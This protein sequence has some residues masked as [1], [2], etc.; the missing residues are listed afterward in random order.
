VI[1]YDLNRNS[2]EPLA[3]QITKV[4]AHGITQGDWKVGDVLPSELWLAKQFGV[5]RDTVRQ[6][7]QKLEREGCLK[8]QRGRGTFIVRAPGNHDFDRRRPVSASAASR[9]ADVPADEAKA[10]S[11]ISATASP[12]L[13]GITQSLRSLLLDLSDETRRRDGLDVV[14]LRQLSR[15]ENRMRLLRVQL[16]VQLEQTQELLNELQAQLTRHKAL[17]QTLVRRAASGPQTRPDPAAV[18]LDID[19]L[20]WSLYHEVSQTVDATGFILAI[21]DESSQT[22]NVVK[23][24]EAGTELPTGSFPLGKGFTSEV[25]RTRQPRLIRRWSKEGPRVQIQYATRQPG[26]PESGITLPLLV[27]DRVLGVM[28]VQSYQPEAYSEDDLLKL[29]AIADRAAIELAELCRPGRSGGQLLRRVSEL[30]TVLANMTDGMLVVDAAGC[31][32]HLNRAAREL[33]CDADH[34]I[35]LGQPL[36]EERWGQRSLSPPSAA[37]A[38][39]SVIKALQQGE[40][41]CEVAVELPGEPHRVLNC[42]GTA[43]RDA[44]GM[45]TGGAIVLRDMTREHE[46]ERIKDEIL[47]IA[48]HDLRSPITAIQSEAR[49]LVRQVSDSLATPEAVTRGLSMIGRQAGHLVELVTLLLEASRIEASRRELQLGLTELLSLVRDAVEGVQATTNRHRIVLQASEPVEGIWDGRRLKE[50]FHNLI[51]TAIKYVPDGGTIVVSI[52]TDEQSATARVREDEVGLAADDRPRVFERTFRD[53]E[54]QGLDD[55]GLGLQI[56]QAIVAA[57]GGQMWAELQGPGCGST[58]CVSLPRTVPGTGQQL[59]GLRAI[60]PGH[61]EQIGE[62]DHEAEAYTTEDHLDRRVGVTPNARAVRL[63]TRG[64]HGART[65]AGS[66]A[67]R[68]DVGKPDGCRPNP[69]PAHHRRDGPR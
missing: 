38:A 57:H 62:I 18:E 25:I 34:N 64:E 43:L 63:S 66:C 46:I 20:A 23:Q 35:I 44:D 50:L 55:A 3:D 42:R 39:S 40:G 36:D 15:W 6:A 67:D 12:D 22:V 4:L 21:Y 65:G 53:R 49:M 17:E 60:S 59:A 30:E 33:L 8:R 41:R 37:E 5:A 47:T 29:Q 9:M 32:I 14:Q 68:P 28:S 61:Q 69:P 58:F 51:S 54:K 24:I 7:I 2:L 31:V 52:E 48:S 11:T 1:S 16:A 19:E 27:E 10:A 26:L 56:C 45:L 13:T